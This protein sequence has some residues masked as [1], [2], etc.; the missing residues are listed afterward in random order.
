MHVT[1]NNELIHHRQKYIPI[2]SMMES[3]AVGRSLAFKG[4]EFECFGEVQ[5]TINDLSTRFS[6]PL[7]IFNS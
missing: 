6:H 3:S 2:L 1:L 7:G 5:S 4:K